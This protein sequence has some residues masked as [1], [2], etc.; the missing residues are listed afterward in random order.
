MEQNKKTEKKNEMAAG[1]LFIL[2]GF[3]L[4]IIHNRVNGSNVKDV[5]SGVLLGMAA[6]SELVGVC[7]L[8]KNGASKKEN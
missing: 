1:L 5:I 7:V 3:G 2:L 4:F 6:I 8:A